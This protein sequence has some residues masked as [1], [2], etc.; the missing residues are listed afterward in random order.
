MLVEDRAEK[1]GEI[2]KM[3]ERVRRVRGREEAGQGREKDR[4]RGMLER[5]E[6]LKILADINDPV[7]KRRFEDGFGMSFLSSLLQTSKYRTRSRPTNQHSQHQA[8]CKN[9]YTA[10]S[11]T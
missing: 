11:R 3:R 1:V 8:T 7:V 6:E 4:L 5:I 10:T 9:P 2:E